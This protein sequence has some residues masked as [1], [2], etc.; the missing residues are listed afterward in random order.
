MAVVDEGDGDVDTL[1]QALGVDAAQDEAAFVQGFGALGGGADA[2]GGEGFADAGEE[3][4]LLGEGAGVGHDREGVHLEAVVVME[5]QGLVLDDARVK[6]EAGG[7]KALAGARVAAVEDGHVVLLGHLVDGVEEGQEVLFRVDVFF[8]VG[9]QQDVLTLFQAQAL[10]DVGGF[11]LR[12]VLVQDFRHRRAGDVGTFLRE[13]AV[14]KITACVLAVSHVD[15]GDN[16]DNPPV[17]LLWQALVLTAVA[18]LHMEDG[19][20]QPL[21]ADDAEAGVRVPQHQHRIGL[22]GHHQLV[23]LGNDIAHGLAQV[24][25]DSVH[26]H[27][28][29][30]KLQILEEHPVQV[31][32]IVLP[33]MRQ[34]RV[35]IRPALVNHS[36]QPDDFRASS[37]DDEKLE[38]A[39]ALK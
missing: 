24:R 14:G 23:A 18:G 16:V 20:V 17:R 33:G 10:M 15:I 36:R 3:A 5:A 28:R 32:I 6:L 29:V 35:K 13:A 8:A 22:D 11:D 30:R 1:E 21:G 38:L 25:A 27:L 39:V 19:D 26:I 31:V 34:N 2:D 37:N 12:Q 7:F 4:A 9:T